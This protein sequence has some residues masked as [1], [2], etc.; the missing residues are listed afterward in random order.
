MAS[1]PAPLPELKPATPKPAPVKEPVAAAV[2]GV[3]AAQE[4][5]KG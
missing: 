5:K 2:N 4:G 3:P 1:P